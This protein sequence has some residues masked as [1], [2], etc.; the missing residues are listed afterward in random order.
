[1]IREGRAGPPSVCQMRGAGA[2]SRVDSG[3]G[4]ECHRGVVRSWPR[5]GVKAGRMLRGLV[6]DLLSFASESVALAF[7]DDDFC[8][9]G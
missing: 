4:G 8:V 6:G 1:M 3:N 5:W 7:E 9:V 2:R